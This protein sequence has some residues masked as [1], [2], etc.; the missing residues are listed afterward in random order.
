MQ[1]ADAGTMTDSIVTPIPTMAAM[2]TV[3]GNSTVDVSG[4]PAPAALKTARRPRATRMPPPM[5]KQGDD[6]HHEGLGVDHPPH[7]LATGADRAHEGEL[8]QP[9][10]DGDLE[11]VVDEER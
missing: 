4:K 3:R 8:A 11:H 7:L 2:I 10:A 1:A 6:G 9:L 5:P